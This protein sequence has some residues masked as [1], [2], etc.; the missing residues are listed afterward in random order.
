MV[1]SRRVKSI[2]VYILMHCENS[3]VKN[4][5]DLTSRGVKMK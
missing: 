1:T 4:E 5:L 2:P 3:G